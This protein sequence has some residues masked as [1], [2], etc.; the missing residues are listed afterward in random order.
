[1]IYRTEQ[2]RILINQIKLLQVL[3][4]IIERLMKGMTLEFATGRVFDLEEKRDVPVNRLML[5]NYLRSLQK[6]LER[7]VEDYYKSKNLNKDIGPEVLRNISRDLKDELSSHQFKQF[8][9]KGYD[10]MISRLL[11]TPQQLAKQPA[12]DDAV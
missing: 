2:K 11:Q 9:I 3:M 5:D 8:E 4:V 1:M 7:N 12:A 10:Q 6:G